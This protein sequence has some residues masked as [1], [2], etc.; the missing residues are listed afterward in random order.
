LKFLPLPIL[1]ALCSVA[2]GQDIKLPATVQ[3]QPGAY[4]EVPATTDGGVVKWL[5]LDAGLNVFPASLLRDTKTNVVSALKPGRYRLIAWTA[6]GDVPSDAAQTIVVIG[7]PPDP[8]PDPPGPD[9]DPEP[10]L[11]GT[12]KAVRDWAKAVGNK[13][14]AKQ[15]A[16]NYATI[17][18]TINA[19]AY[20]S[21][22]FAD[23]RSKIV[24][25]VYQLNQKVSA[26]NEEWGAFFRNLSEHL[27]ALDTEG[28][29]DSVDKIKTVFQDIQAG[30]EAASE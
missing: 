5:A 27:K 6:K 8:D 22:S 19:G 29:L 25:D 18:S 24:S 23:A 3:G 26:N 14:E 30:L 9:P 11:T 7:N 4:I 2:L 15:I 20:A 10:D 12:A 28:K 21:L 16:E 17:L 1:L 13:V